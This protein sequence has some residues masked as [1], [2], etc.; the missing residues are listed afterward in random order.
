LRAQNANKQIE[1]ARK[2][3]IREVRA[4]T[5][6]RIYR[7]YV[8]RCEAIR[9]YERKQ[10]DLAYVA[11][12]QKKIRLIQ[13]IAKGKIGRIR[14]QQR[15]DEIALFK[16]RWHKAREIQRVYRGH[17]GRLR[18]KYFQELARQKKRN[19][20]AL[21]IQYNYRGYR[22]RLLAAVARAL[23]LLRA[24]QQ[25]CAVEIQR[26]L[27]GCMGRHRFKVHKEFVTRRNRQVLACVQIQ[28]MFRGHKGREAREIEY[29]LQK[30][31]NSARPLIAH[32]HQVEDEA[33]KLRN[34]IRKLEVI[35]KRMHEEL[36]QIEREL[37]H[38]LKTTNK[39]TDSGRI[40]QTPQRF[41][42]KFLRVRL[43]DHLD[44]EVVS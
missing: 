29:H 10:H 43:K 6:Q 40:N 3:A 15:R 38:C 14:A 23:R 13:R 42:T 22:G 17:R 19:A 37:E 9:R 7:G 33:D 12:V 1:A 2:R 8:A 5:I 30:L 34:V 44:H 31:E 41:L 11:M 27:R 25:F 21:I 20:A 16:L 4:I 32:L 24:K 36:F 35:E 18:F 39:Y 28:R 26:F